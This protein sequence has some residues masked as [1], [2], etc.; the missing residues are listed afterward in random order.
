MKSNVFILLTKICFTFSDKT[1]KSTTRTSSFQGRRV[2]CH[3]LWVEKFLQFGDFFANFNHVFLVYLKHLRLIHILVDPGK[4]R[5]NSSVH[6]R[7]E[8]LTTRW[9]SVTDQTDEFPSCWRCFYIRIEQRLAAITGAKRHL[10][11]KH[12]NVLFK[13]ITYHE[14]LPS[15]PSAHICVFDMGWRSGL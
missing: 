3:Q 10:Y 2:M 12:S 1:N 7:F 5:T 6:T 11:F 4:E 15:L 8:I 14:S 13:L 9:W